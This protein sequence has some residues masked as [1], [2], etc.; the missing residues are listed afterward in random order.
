MP[1][2]G[3]GNPGRLQGGDDVVV[4]FKCEEELGKQQRR[5][6]RKGIQVE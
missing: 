6:G 5:K 2:E 1:G 3:K 4:V